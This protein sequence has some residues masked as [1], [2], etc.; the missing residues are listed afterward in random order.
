MRRELIAVGI[1]AVRLAHESSDEPT[2]VVERIEQDVYKIRDRDDRTTVVSAGQASV[3]ALRNALSRE[4]GKVGGIRTGF[5]Y[6]DHVLDGLRPGEVII[7]AAR[8][9]MGKSALALNVA[10]QIARQG[11]PTGFFSLE[12]THEP[13][14]LR[15][16]SSMSAVP[17]S[18]IRRSQMD[19]DERQG[20]ERMSTQIE[21]MPLYIDD[22]P[23]LTLT[24]L[25]AKARR[26]ARRWR[27]QLLII[28]YLQLL[29]DPSANGSTER[30]TNSSAA[31]KALARELNVGVMCLSQLNRQSEFRSDKRPTLADLRDSGA[32]EQDA[33]VVML[34][35]RPDYYAQPEQ[36][37]GAAELIIAK[38]RSGETVRIDMRWLP[39]RT[40]F[41]E[42]HR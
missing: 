3:D 28:D 26:H 12:M 39:E 2:E 30:A 11:I 1:D 38:N 29:R 10:E 42:V 33:D 32:I 4:P 41:Y 7:L 9:S 36:A 14:A 16:L 15:L 5:S 6:L 25:R 17:I 20:V 8:P 37:T 31:V 22:S 24:S 13:L 34:L 35:H 40:R 19:E 27:L 21:A 23:G 18:K